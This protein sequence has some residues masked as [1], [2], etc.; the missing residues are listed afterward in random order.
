VKRSLFLD[1]D[2]K[3]RTRSSEF[4]AELIASRG[5]VLR[6]WDATWRGGPSADLTAATRGGELDAAV[7]FQALPPA[8]QVLRVP[9]RCRTWVPMSDVLDTVPDAAL[10]PYRLTGLRVVCFCRALY[11]RLRRLG[12]PSLY[13]QYFPEPPAEAVDGRG[14]LRVFFWQR[15]AQPGWQ[16][17][18]ALLGGQRPERTCLLVAPDPGVRADE[19]TPDDAGRYHVTRVTGFLAPAEFHR[20]MRTCNVFIAPRS[21]EGIGMTFLEAMAH[22]LCVVAAEG[23]TM[24][25]YITHGVNGLLYRPGAV[26]PLDL[27]AAAALGAAARE[28][29]C[30]GRAAWSADAERVLR[31]VFGEDE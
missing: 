28:S 10:R 19:P 4:F 27:S 12:F 8:S 11:E 17:V 26:G 24:S 6:A 15:R 7:F 9:A 25:E 18:K 29:A 5:E 16:T 20:L 13:A 23:P 3:Q 14:G 21:R 31:F 30:R 1:M 2:F 22:G